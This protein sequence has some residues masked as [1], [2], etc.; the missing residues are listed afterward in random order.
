MSSNSLLS[1]KPCEG[2][3]CPHFKCLKKALRIVRRSSLVTVICSLTNDQCIGAKCQFAVC[4]A[5]AM[6]A[7][8][9]CMFEFRKREEKEID[10][11]EEAKKMERELSRIKSRFRKIGLEDYL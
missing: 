11:V 4:D 7:D 6:S 1:P 2:P 10:I 8:G 9:K 5:H 3:K